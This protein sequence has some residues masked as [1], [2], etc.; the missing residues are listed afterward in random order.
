MIPPTSGL[1]CVTRAP[2]PTAAA[3]HA[4]VSGGGERRSGSTIATQAGGAS[5]CLDLT[6][7]VVK[8][9]SLQETAR[10]TSLATFASSAAVN[11]LSAKYVGH[12]SPSSRL[13]LSVNPRVA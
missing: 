1:H 2:D 3:T 11:V 8:S 7:R 5:S 13:A 9:M 6:D 4:R 12:I 10:F